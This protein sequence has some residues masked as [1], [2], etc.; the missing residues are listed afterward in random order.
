MKKILIIDDEEDI[1][2]LAKKTFENVGNFNFR[3]ALTGNGGIALFKSFK[4][5]LVFVDLKLPDIDGI[6]C[7]KQIS[8]LNRNTP[9]VM[10]S[11]KGTHDY[12]QK[13]FEAGAVDFL[14]KPCDLTRL[15][16]M[17]EKQLHIQA[18]SRKVSKSAPEDESLSKMLFFDTLFSLVSVA[19]AKSIYL[20]GH[21][22]R[23]AELS[24]KIGLRLKLN[25]D[26]L[27]ILRCS[28]ILHD[29]GK[30]GIRDATLE[31]PGTFNDKDWQEIK[32]HPGI[33]SE[34]VD[35]MRLFRLECPNIMHH[36]ERFD[37]KGY[38]DGLKGE[39]IPLGARIIALA[40][41]FDAMT[42]WRPYRKAMANEKAV[43]IIKE[44]SGTQ[45]DPKVVEAFLKVRASGG[46]RI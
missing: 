32:K 10:F 42:S 15:I 17:A 5:N 20:K 19:E 39:N 37:G 29:I 35:K 28:A 26:E 3:Y 2:L 40:D 27:E 25:K 30:V 6:N 4:P 33:G 21:S 44:C 31:K 18:E 38:P 16:E 12:M 11:G 14:V 43:G 34:I 13:A 23:V 9:V 1:C 24:R 45:F 7:I 46:E 22:E 36:H 8:K 41:S